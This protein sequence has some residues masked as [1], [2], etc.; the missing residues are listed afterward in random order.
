MINFSPYIQYSFQKKIQLWENVHNLCKQIQ[1]GRHVVQNEVSLQDM[2]KEKL[3]Q[4]NCTPNFPENK[5][6]NNFL[7]IFFQHPLYL[8]TMG[9]KSFFQFFFF[10]G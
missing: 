9:K 1:D 6:M 3:F 4:A 5:Q 2:L 8:K 7:H 10:R